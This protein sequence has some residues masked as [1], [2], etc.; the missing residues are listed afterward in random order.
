MRAFHP[1]TGVSYGISQG[2]TVFPT[3]G[4]PIT[5]SGL[6]AITK[7]YPVKMIISGRSYLEQ[8]VSSFPTFGG[9]PSNPLL[10]LNNGIRAEITINQNSGVIGICET[11]P[12]SS[13][14]DV[15]H[16]TTRTYPISNNLHKVL[17]SY[18]A[19]YAHYVD[20]TLENPTPGNYVGLGQVLNQIGSE[21]IDIDPHVFQVGD[22]V[23]VHSS[24]TPALAGTHTVIDVIDKYN[25]VINLAYPGG[26][27][28][29][30]GQ[31]GF[32]HTIMEEKDQT[33][34]QSAEILINP[35]TNT[36]ST[37]NAY[38]FGNGLESDRIR[39]AFNMTTI[40]YSPRA[41]TNIQDYDRERKE[42]SLT[43][44]G[45]YTDKTSTNALNEFNLSLVNFKNLDSGF[46]SIQKI[47]ARDTDLLVL[48]EDKVS[49]V[50]YGK[51]LLSDAVGGGAVTSSPQVLGNQ[52]SDRG[53]WG[54]SFNPESFAEWGSRIY[55]TDSRRGAVLSIEN[56]SIVPISDLGMRS[57]FRDLMKDNSDTQKIGV[58]DPSNQTYVLASN[59][60]TSRPCTLTL[61]A[62]GDDYPSN[63]IN[64][65][66]VVGKYEA[67]FVVFSNT[68][69]TAAIAYSAG[70]DWVTGWPAT[71]HGDQ[72]VDLQVANNT[73]GSVRT[74][75]ITF[76]FCGSQTVTYVVTQAAGI[77]IIVH[78]WVIGNE[79]KD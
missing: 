22:Q 44:S 66:G 7:K 57:Y 41:S 30:V 51:N 69:W 47:H 9:V 61:N 72:A 39:D 67:D 50:L 54:I 65:V 18:K 76:T 55:W 42:A 37:Y 6:T 20:V 31:V 12:K 16:E 45:I 77:G 64:E 17:W 8:E 62:S 28:A 74:A 59:E 43:Y 58:F 11:V 73:T 29:S 78:P 63:I 34:V 46:G 68:T 10:S 49:R 38:S 53:E 56:Q 3:D 5:D 14:I 24:A 27:S 48:Q 75:T 36:N 4:T 35:T 40:E 1:A 60:E 25:I 33:N 19:F 71:G 21:P 70:S 13:D 26:A 79:I 15:Y 2:G 32:Y 52:I 23:E